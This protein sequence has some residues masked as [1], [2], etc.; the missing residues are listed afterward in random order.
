MVEEGGAA[1]AQQ[2]FGEVAGDIVKL[3]VDTNGHTLV[4]ALIQY[5]TDKYINHVLQIL[6]AASPFQISS[7]LPE[8]T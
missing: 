5:L 6:D 3:M 7:Q 1:T 2:V 8:T 4:G